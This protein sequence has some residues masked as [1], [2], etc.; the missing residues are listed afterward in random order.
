MLGNFDAALEWA[1]E[2]VDRQKDWFRAHHWV[3]ESLVR[4]GRLEEARAAVRAYLEVFPHGSLADAE[5][6]P[7]KSESS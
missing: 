5:Q 6:Y 3:T 2:S 4:L 7:Q 1:K